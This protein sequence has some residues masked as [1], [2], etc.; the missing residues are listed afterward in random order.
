MQSF[1]YE[2]YIIGLHFLTMNNELFLNYFFPSTF[3][4]YKSIV[5]S[6]NSKRKCCF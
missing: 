6:V 2:Y 3:N 5:I 4:Q 1:V